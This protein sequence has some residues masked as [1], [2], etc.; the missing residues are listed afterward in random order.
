VPALLDRWANDVEHYISSALILCIIG[1]GLQRWRGRRGLGSAARV[2][3][4]WALRGAAMAVYYCGPRGPP[5]NKTIVAPL[6]DIVVDA[7]RRKPP[8]Q[9]ARGCPHKPAL[10]GGIAWPPASR[11]ANNTNC[12]ASTGAGGEGTG[13]TQLMTALSEVLA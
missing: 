13:G 7:G 12:A 10:H 11:P 9:K 8:V 2:M 6:Q 4:G 3:Q 1:G 5:S